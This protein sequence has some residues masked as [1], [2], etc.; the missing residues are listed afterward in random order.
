MRSSARYTRTAVW[1][2]WLLA[3][4]LLGQIAF[5]FL[6]DEIAPRATP[7][8]SGVVNLHKSFG[9]VLG[10]LIAARLGWR[11]SHAPPPWP[12]TMREVERRAARSVH[13]ALYVC[14]AVMPLSGYVAS[15]FSRFGITFFGI[16]WPPW[17]PPLPS[18][19][20]FFHGVHVT[21]AWIFCA[22]IAGHVLA[23]LK[24]AVV[25]RDGVFAR[26]LN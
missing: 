13:V 15:N 4:A 22:L 24:H 20:A 11:I 14:M 3:A 8:R 2:H 12:A 16:A 17:G 9:I 7:A 26:M 6:L 18:V 25:D 10:L 23:A 5:G 21:T 19:Y 1:L